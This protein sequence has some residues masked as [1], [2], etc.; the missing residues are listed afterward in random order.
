MK[1]L[2]IG[3]YKEQSDWG[4][5]TVNNILALDRAGVDVVCRSI[6][7]G[8][9][10]TPDAIRH[11]ENKD[12]GDATHC[13]Q[14]VFSEHMVGTNKFQK[15]VGILSNNFVEM[16]HGSWVEKLQLPDEVWVPTNYCWIEHLPEVIKSRA[17]VM[18]FAIDTDVYNRRYNTL[19]I[20]EVVNDFKIYTFANTNE[21]NSL[22]WLLA[23]FHSEFDGT[24]P[25]SLVIYLKP[26]QNGQ[27]EAQFIEELSRKIKGLLRLEKSPE[28][29]RRDVI[30]TS[31]GLSSANLCEI[32]Q[33][34]DCYVTTNT[35][36]AFPQSEIDAFGF[37]N[38]PIVSSR[39]SVTEYIGKEN[40]VPSVYQVIQAQGSMF[41]DTNNGRD[42]WIRPDEYHLKQKMRAAFNAWKENPMQY[43]LDNKK[44]AL[45]TLSEF[46]L[47]NVGQKMKEALSV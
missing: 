36:F 14:H 33:A 32:H 7:L 25:V 26:Q 43:K 30:I 29:H 44:A 3:Y 6:E 10:E 34:C 5:Q 1:V 15:N 18:P 20:K 47:E 21:T 41:A 40:T 17:K 35:D 31:P 27:Q 46:S 11:L 16:G 9:K 37:G 22:T 19:N 39:S 2:Y 23:T 8:G 4:K 12:I 38:K 42:Y 13:V 28:L 24:E 45:Q